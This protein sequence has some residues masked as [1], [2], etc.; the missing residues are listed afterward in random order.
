LLYN[1]L[2]LKEIIMEV[3]MSELDQVIN[4]SE[5][6]VLV[7]FWAAWC[8]PCKAYA[9]TF[10]QFSEANPEVK[11]LSVDC[12]KNRDIAEKYDVMSIPVTLLFKDKT[13]VA[14]KAGKLTADQLTSMLGE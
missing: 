7:K 4:T 5:G 14:K 9:P 12:D 6:P 10:E 3:N 1:I 11:C 8:G 2:V 13:L